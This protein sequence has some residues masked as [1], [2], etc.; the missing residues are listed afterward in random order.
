MMHE[1]ALCLMEAS[2]ELMKLSQSFQ[3]VAARL[4]VALTH[5]E[6]PLQLPVMR[7]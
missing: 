1:H 3:W 7:F 4:H 5:Q 2:S 6:A